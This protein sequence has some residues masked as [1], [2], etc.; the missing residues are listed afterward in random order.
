MGPG[1]AGR[2][3]SHQKKKADIDAMIYMRDMIGL[4]FTNEELEYYPFVE[5]G[6]MPELEEYMKQR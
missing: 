4:E 3:T 1:F 2:N 6:M 5:P